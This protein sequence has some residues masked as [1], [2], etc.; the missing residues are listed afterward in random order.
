MHVE[1]VI[2]ASPT[3]SGKECGLRRATEYDKNRNTNGHVQQFASREGKKTALRFEYVLL[4]CFLLR[5]L[6]ASECSV[7]DMPRQRAQYVQA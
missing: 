3:R 7:S 6:S 1:T 5:L 4:P 2:P